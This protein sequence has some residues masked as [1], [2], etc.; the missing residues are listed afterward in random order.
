MFSTKVKPTVILNQ[1][2][3]YGNDRIGKRLIRLK[4]TN[5]KTV[6]LTSGPIVSKG[7]SP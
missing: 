3:D 4:K 2:L 5:S 6:N 1:V 7:S